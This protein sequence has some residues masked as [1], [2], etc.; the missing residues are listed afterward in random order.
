M[1]LLSG[2]ASCMRFNLTSMP[3]TPQF[4]LLPFRPIT[5]GGS[6]R[7]REGFIPFEPGEPYDWG[8]RGWAFRVRIDK[9][10]LDNTVISERLKELI[11][12]ESETVGPPSI[13][14]IRKLRTL[15]EDELMAHPMPRSRVIE[16]VLG[17]TELY[18][19]STAKSH[20]GT[21]LE[22][23]KRVGVEVT[24][25]TPWLDAGQEEELSEMVDLKE[26]G[27][28]IWGCRFL[29]ALLKDPDTLVE[30]ENGNVR[31]V[32]EDRAKVSLSGPVLNELDRY[33]ER[34]A[35]LLSARLL[36]DTF[37][38]RFDALSYRINGLK[39]DNLKNKP[40]QERLETRLEKLGKLWEWLDTKY[41]V[42]M[43][44]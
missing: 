7:E 14:T 40:W 15:A 36:V 43:K 39:L 35:E 9:V 33:L 25:K 42:L 10:H 8:P 44:P 6:I 31:L 23:L 16:C 12:A 11:K 32:T 38:F 24:F 18:V 1:G 26:P 21:V 3:E 34:G 5:P 22:L 4:D 19:G 29:K 13:Q 41:Q 27:Q 20:V 2:S 37:N 28:S 30:P 17:E